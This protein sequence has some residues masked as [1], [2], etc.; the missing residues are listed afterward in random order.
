MLPRASSLTSLEHVYSPT[1]NCSKNPSTR[2]IV[3]LSYLRHPTLRPLYFP[4]RYR[5]NPCLVRHCSFA[6]GFRFLSVRVFSSP[7]L[8]LPRAVWLD[9]AFRLKPLLRVT[10][11]DRARLRLAPLNLTLRSE[12]PVVDAECWV[13]PPTPVDTR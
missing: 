10:F 5:S 12:N 3:R 6:L 1:V 2:D 11:F 8:A 7:A 13:A 4:F 9:P